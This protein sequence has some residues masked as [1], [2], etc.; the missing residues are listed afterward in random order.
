MDLESD[1]DRSHVSVDLKGVEVAEERHSVVFA[2]LFFGLEEHAVSQ[3]Q[4]RC[5]YP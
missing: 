2:M 3:A 4:H 5:D 1:V